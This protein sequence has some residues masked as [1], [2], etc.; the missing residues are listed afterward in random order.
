MA[1]LFGMRDTAD[2]SSPDYRPKNYREMAFKLWPN[3]PAPLTDLLS[4]LPSRTV[5]DPEYKI[6]EWR[7]PQQVWTLTAADGGDAGNPDTSVLGVAA[8]TAYGLKVGDLLE[9]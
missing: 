6:F 1:N 9:E 7:L 5:D 4:K 2:W 8:G 3:S